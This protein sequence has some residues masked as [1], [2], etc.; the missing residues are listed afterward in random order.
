MTEFRDAP[1]RLAAWDAMTLNQAA[2]GIVGSILS[3]YL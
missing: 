1:Q 3:K 2:E